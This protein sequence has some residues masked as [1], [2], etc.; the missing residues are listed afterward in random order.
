MLNAHYASFSNDGKYTPPLRKPNEPI[1]GSVQIVSEE[2]VF[3]LLDNLGATSAGTDGIP[4]WFLRMAALS[5][6]A[7]V[8]HVY[9]LALSHSYVPEQWKS[10]V[11]TPVPKVAQPKACEDFRPITVTPILSRLLKKLVVRH[12]IYPVL[13][14]NDDLSDQFAFRPTGSTTAALINLLHKASALLQDHDLDLLG[15]EAFAT[16]VCA[17]AAP[18]SRSSR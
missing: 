18:S 12:F 13:I 17:S 16:L 3:N 6:A 7:P 2:Q 1:E 10:G 8:A 11:I 15:L 5:F 14:E 4:H 9:N